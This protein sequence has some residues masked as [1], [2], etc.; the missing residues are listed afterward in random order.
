MIDY[1]LCKKDLIDTT[2]HKIHFGSNFY[3][4]IC[5]INEYNI[6]IKDKYN[7]I[8]MF[9]N[10]THSYYYIYD[11]FYTIEELRQLKLESI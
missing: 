2:Y 3:Y 4:R 8:F 1:F 7:K 11:Y 6:Y 10:Y 9:D 5:E